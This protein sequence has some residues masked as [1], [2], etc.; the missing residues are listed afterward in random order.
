MAQPILSLAASNVPSLPKATPHLLPC[1]IH[2]D[3]SV[4]PAAEQFWAPTTSSS[5]SSSSADNNNNT[6]KKTAY[7]RGRKLQ[8]RTLRLPPDYRG[9]VAV[10]PPKQTDA[11]E[12]DVGVDTVDLTNESPSGARSGDMRVLAEF[13]EV[14]VWN[15]EGDGADKEGE[16]DPYVR[17]VEEWLGIAEQIHAF[18]VDGKK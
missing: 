4:E 3:G 7:F 2:H 5:S 16:G 18:D 6:D 13:G 11:E 14:V 12:E 10:P 1:H 8:S 17:G 9:I 15:H